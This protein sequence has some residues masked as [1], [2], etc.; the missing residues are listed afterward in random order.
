MLFNRF[1]HSAHF[2]NAQRHAA[3]LYIFLVFM[4]VFGIWP[5]L[6]IHRGMWPGYIFSRFYEHFFA[7]VGFKSFL[8]FCPFSK[9][10]KACDPVI[11]FSRFMCVFGILPIFEMHKNMRSG[12][13]FFSYHER[14]WHF[15]NFGNAQ[16]HVVRSYFFSFHARPQKS[17]LSVVKQVKKKFS[18][19]AI[20]KRLHFNRNVFKEIETALHIFS[21][22][23]KAYFNHG[24]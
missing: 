12:Y 18:F 16:R 19:R 4:S 7:F 11:H 13:T 10:T 24:W 14:F 5:I 8:A 23:S 3:R 9:C 22:R 6:E 21:S 20:E 17:Y 1:W 2:R 15:A